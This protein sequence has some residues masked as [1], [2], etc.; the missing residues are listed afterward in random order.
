MN[1]Q[2]INTTWQQQAK[3]HLIQRSHSKQTSLPLKNEYRL[4][5][6]EGPLI[7]NDGYVALERPQSFVCTML[8]VL[9]HG[10]KKQ[11]VAINH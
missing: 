7:T 2:V 5:K 3:K 1:L 8:M 9:V 11:V 4:T 6:R 10:V